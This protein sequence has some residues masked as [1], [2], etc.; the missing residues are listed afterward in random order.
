MKSVILLILVILATAF[1]NVVKKVYGNKTE[2]RGTYI[3]SSLVVL[4]LLCFL[5]SPIPMVS[6]LV[7][8]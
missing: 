7:Q 2:G 3:F 1:Q 6:A 5:L 4:Q 8:S